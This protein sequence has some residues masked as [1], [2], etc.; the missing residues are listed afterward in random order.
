MKILHLIYDYPS[1]PWVGGGGAVRAYELCRLL[2]QKG[3]EITVLSG[4]YP[5]AKDFKDGSLEYRFIGTD[6]NYLLSTFSYAF[7]AAMHVRKYSSEYDVV[8]EDFAPWNPVFSVSLTR[9]PTVLHVN[10]REGLNILRRWNILGIP[11][12]MVEMFYPGRFKYVTAL[13]EGTKKKLGLPQTVVLP[14]GISEDVL[15]GTEEGGEGGDE[16]YV[17]YVGRLHIGNKGLDT[18]MEALRK[19]KDEGRGVRLLLAGR[20]KDEARL[21]EMAR[22]LDVEFLGFVDEERK[23]DLMRHAALFVLPSRFEGWGIVLLEAA[24]CG[25]AVLVS[26]IPELSFPVEAGYGRA[27]RCGAPE[28]L[29]GK[30]SSLLGDAELRAEMG[31]RAREYVKDYTWERIAGDYVSYLEGILSAEAGREPSKSN[32]L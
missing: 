28:D 6:R 19:I 18:L 16:G 10:H 31:K 7:E 30:L 26:D 1:N 12:Y 14:A 4:R 9:K 20:G 13:S 27:F 17:L 5:G 15:T 8:V 29:A 22:G 21:K 25:R 23:I 32:E 3:H 11:F 24:A 2:A